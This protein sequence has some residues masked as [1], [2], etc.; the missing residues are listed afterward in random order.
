MPEPLPPTP[1]LPSSQAGA[2]PAPGT[3]TF[4]SGAPAAQDQSPYDPE[5]DFRFPP[6]LCWITVAGTTDL[7]FPGGG[8]GEVV[9]DKAQ[10]ILAG[11]PWSRVKGITIEDLPAAQAQLQFFTED[12]LTMIHE[13]GI[14]PSASA[15]RVPFWLPFGGE[16]EKGGMPLFVPWGVKATQTD[17]R[18]Y[19]WFERFRG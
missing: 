5:Q 14:G 3:P 6:S 12:G 15:P 4:L 13:V 8:W 1:L 7:L 17:L 2:T 19:V 11:D 18:V 10:S 16:G 9:R